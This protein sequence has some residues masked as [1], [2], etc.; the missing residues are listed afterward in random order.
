V[1]LLS[2]RVVNLSLLSYHLFEYIDFWAF[3]N[4]DVVDI[5]GNRLLEGFGNKAFD[6]IFDNTSQSYN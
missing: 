2:R 5:L 4:N 3:Q 1:V 6:Y